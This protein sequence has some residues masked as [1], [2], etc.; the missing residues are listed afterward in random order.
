MLGSKTVG[1][2]LVFGAGYVVG[3]RAGRERYD[4]IKQAA[5]ALGSEAR[6]RLRE[7]RNDQVQAVR[8]R[9]RPLWDDHDI[10]LGGR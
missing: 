3:T 1:R 9:T 7:S 5:L 2:S 8:H 6:Q 4:Q 10:T